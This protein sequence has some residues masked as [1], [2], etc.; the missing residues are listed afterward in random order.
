MNNG[1]YQRD[2]RDF[3]TGP[4]VVQLSAKSVVV[5]GKVNGSNQASERVPIG[6]TGSVESGIAASRLVVA[7]GVRLQGAW[8]CRAWAGASGRTSDTAR[9][10]SPRP[11][12][13]PGKDSGRK[14]YPEA[15][16][17]QMWPTSGESS[18]SGANPLP[19][20]RPTANRRDRAAGRWARQEE[21]PQG[22]R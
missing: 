12:G 19:V 21:G 4:P 20:F 18:S 7:V 9:F 13:F 17:L 6:E 16:A 3:C 22:G 14:H 15:N 10:P 1:R 5:L 2:G 11:W 8:T